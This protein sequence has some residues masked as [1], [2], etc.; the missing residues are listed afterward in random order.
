MKLIES[1]TLATAAAQIEFTLIPQDG[2]D[3]VVFA[4]ARSSR[5]AVGDGFY[6]TI[7]G[8]TANQTNRYLEGTGSSVAS[9]TESRFVGSISA[10]TSTSNTFG[11]FGLYFSNYAGGANK[12]FSVDSVWEDNAT[13][14]DQVIIAG[15]WSQTAAITSLTFV[16]S[17]GPNFVAGSTISLYKVTK[18]SDGIVT[19]S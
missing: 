12:S 19:T 15:L 11:N 8:S 16:P 4:S 17:V 7:N 1:K 5:S 2:T 10:A 6:L 3:L 9:G 18:G 13:R 14:A